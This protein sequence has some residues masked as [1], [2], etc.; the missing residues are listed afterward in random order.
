MIADFQ[1][2]CLNCKAINRFFLRIYDFLN[3]RRWL[4]GLIAVAIAALCGL[5][6]MRLNYEEDIAKFLPS[7]EESAKYSEAYND[8]G[9]KNN[10]V[11]IFSSKGEPLGNDGDGQDIGVEAEEASNGISGIGSGA[12]DAGEEDY[13][14]TIE[15]AMD[16]FGEEFAQIDS[17][18]M[19]AGRQI[20]V[21]GE[22]SL[23]M[24]EAVMQNYPLFMTENDYSRIDSLLSTPDF[25]KNQLQADR[26]ALMFPTGDLV[27]ES[28]STDPLHLF[29]PILQRFRA[30][31]ANEGYTVSDDYIFI[32]P[33]SGKPDGIEGSQPAA[34]MKGIAFLTSPYGTSESGM[35]AKVAKMVQTAIDSTE[36]ANPNI[37]ITAVGAPLIA[38]TNATQIKKDS[39]LAV[40]IAFLLIVIIL[41]LSYRRFSDIFWIIASTAFG[42]LLALGIM[43]LI[44]HSMSIIV[45]GVASVI[46]G[47]AVNYPLHYMDG[48]KTGITPRQ[49]LREMIE[50]LLIGNIT[51]IAAF[52][53][54]VFLN[55][56]A[57][58]DMGLFASLMLAG[59]I[60]FVLIFLPVFAR[61]RGTSQKTIELGRILP[62]K[63]PSS[64]WLFLAVIAATVVLG[65]FSSRTKFD[66]NMQSINYM[67]KEQK[68]ALALLEPHG[69]DSEM[70][71][72][73]EGATLEEALE[74]ND[75]LLKSIAKLD[76]KVKGAGN[77][78]PSLEEQRRRIERW[79]A[80]WGDGK[81]EKLIEE[82]LSEGRSA[83]FSETA[84][85]PFMNML[86]S[87]PKPSEITMDSPLA[88]AFD[89]TYIL[90]GDDGYRIVNQIYYQNPELRRSIKSSLGGPGRLVF[91]TADISSR[92]A[93]MLS[94]NFDFIGIVCSLVV[95]IFLCL[96]FRRLE[97]S[98]LAFI[99]LA[100]SWFWILGIMG[101][102][103]IRFNIV[104]IILATFIFGQGDDYTIFMT[105]AMIYEYAYGRK[106]VATYKNSIFNSALIMFIGIGALVLAK[107]PAMR[108]LGIVTVIGMFVVVAM[109]YY[110]PPVIFRWL[111]EKHG[112]KRDVPITLGRLLRSLWA[113][114][115]Y[116]LIMFLFVDPYTFFHFLFH[117]GEKAKESYHRFVMNISKFIVKHIPGVK[118]T[119]SNPY[120]TT[121]EKPAIIIANHQSH[122]DATCLLT[123]YPKLVFATNSWVWINP[124]YSYMLRKAENYPIADGLEKNLDKI[125]DLVSRGY[126][127][128]VFPE[129]TRTFDGSIGRFHKGAFYA[130]QML[131]LDIV[132]VCFHGAYNALPKWDFMLRKGSIHMEIGQRMAP[133][134]DYREAAKDFRH[135]MINEYAELHRRLADPEY[136]AGYVMSK[137]LYKGAD[138]ESRA[139]QALRTVL[140]ASSGS[141]PEP[142]KNAAQPEPEAG[143]P[144]S[145]TTFNI[146]NCGIGVYSL[147][148]ALMHPETEV[149]ATD[150]SEENIQIAANCSNLPRN[151]HYHL[152]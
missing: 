44:R 1:G 71:A 52:L 47:I 67:T 110:L 135:A 84:F 46:I 129:G 57:M 78:L 85:E 11:L 136:F 12:S 43:A 126:S 121:F 97:L 142:L 58:Q 83:G 151:L 68:E 112:V 64:G 116:S 17:T 27:A 60:I 32:N 40:S 28:L 7:D 96:S 91:D 127:I 114:T 13:E 120:G 145:P 152:G 77:M 130:S 48:L 72:M 144:V 117:K 49:N 105:E 132:P 30:T 33:N 87:Q 2:K 79:N 59:T 3:G 25:I 31:S 137:Y 150:P 118:F 101:I 102:F 74:Q 54:L 143:S 148:Y 123:M 73:A 128:I 81:A 62:E 82:L 34:A 4:A 98:L 10:I 89:G 21:D 86:S 149:Y 104:N 50:P 39:V 75:E 61:K 108:S 53:C 24:M 36:A 22:K 18:N 147:M 115:A 8:L 56:V 51:T 69:D 107:H 19:I 124:L 35:N 134:A 41:I 45:L 66:S 88:A 109:A 122:F 23:K 92:L 146:P 138:I 15:D 76:A 111:T 125:R 16:G 93:T 65:I 103:D 99:P 94:E 100:V 26:Q 80:F 29:S 20:R 139:R 5:L 37:K 131:G 141:Y 14:Y 70:Y 90:Q 63:A 119:V 113:I 42:W 106:R 38:A 95:F 133:V 55:A 9:R 6:A 140:G